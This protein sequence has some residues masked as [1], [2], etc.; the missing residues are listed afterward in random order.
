[1]S[2]TTPTPTSLDG[3][4]SEDFWQRK[5]AAW[6]QEEQQIIFAMQGLE[7][8]SPDTL[9][10]AKRTL[11]PANKAYFLYVTQNPADQGKLLKR[12][13]LNCRVD[14]ASLYPTYRKPFDMIFERAK[15]QEWS[16]LAD[17]FR[18]FHLASPWWGETDDFRTFVLLSPL[19]STEGIPAGP[20]NSLPA[21]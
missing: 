4:I 12:V 2:L 17:D 16:A 9:L 6:Q 18:T 5:N 11:A 7:Q 3:K 21:A 10:A 15:N 14:G 1:M 13:L 19:N 8:A 20:V